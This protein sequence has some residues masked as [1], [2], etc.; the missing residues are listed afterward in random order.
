MSQE[1]SQRVPQQGNGHNEDSTS[2]PSYED[3][4]VD[5]LIGLLR[6]KIDEDKRISNNIKTDI[7]IIYWKTKLL[8]ENEQAKD[9]EIE[10]LKTDN[11]RLIQLLA[12]NSSKM[13]NTNRTYAGALKKTTTEHIVQ[14]YPKQHE[15]N[16]PEA[17][18]QLLKTKIPLLDS[19]CVD[20]IKKSKSN[21]VTVKCRNAA[22]A[23]K[24][25]QTAEVN[26]FEANVPEKRNQVCTLLIRGRDVNEDIAENIIKK[27]PHLPN[28][29]QKLKILNC[30]A[31]KNGNTIAVIETPPETFT[32]LKNE[33]FLI[34]YNWER[35]RLRVQDPITQCHKCLKFG[36][37]MKFCR[38]GE[39]CA[40]C[41]T[42]HQPNQ[43][44][45]PN[46][47]IRCSNCCDYNE[48]ALK[49]N[50]KVKSTNHR[51]TD[52]KCPSRLQAIKNASAF[53]H[54]D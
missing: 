48:F 8:T 3:L 17:T 38:S 42:C 13:E 31:T 32:A 24:L 1:Q 47:E 45:D 54:A 16:S 19:I 40:Q 51:A 25:C 44:C 50:W 28:N 36:H 35:C 6:K 33:N 30:R 20:S 41:A 18:K 10:R 43:P 12:Q 27:N 39:K 11:S 53:Y 14:I 52:S 5:Q 4:P 9:L 26:G 21:G 23:A 37:K 46:H 22:D 29:E 7:A 2:T 49:R 15:V 34:Y